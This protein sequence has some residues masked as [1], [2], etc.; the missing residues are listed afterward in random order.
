[1]HSG[2]EKKYK[3]LIS[4]LDRYVAEGKLV[5]RRKSF[6]DTPTEERENQA[7]ARAFIH[8]YLASTYGVL[9]FEEREKYNH[10]FRR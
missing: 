5:G 9:D 2:Q 10:R 3:V 6:Y 1:M 7:R 8:L 4:I